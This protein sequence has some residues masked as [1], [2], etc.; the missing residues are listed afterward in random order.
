MVTILSLWLP[1]LLS[2]V[3]VFVI[4]SLIHMFFGY[5]A[6]D[7]RKVPDETSFAEA[8]RKLN[9]PPGSYSFPRAGSMAE[10]RSPAYLEK[11]KQNPGV[12]FTLWPAGEIS[13]GSLLIQWFLYSIVVGVFAAYVAGRALDANAHYLAV[14]R[15][16][17]VTAFVSYTLAGW[18][19]SI[20][21]K[22]PWST[23]MKNT[24][25]GLLYALVTAG[26]FGWLWPR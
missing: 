24:F 5:H 3:F 1:I 9:I 21:F 12:M 13:M 18:S 11:V 8:I 6:N 17:G 2:A 22:R 14:F 23:T 20:W 7:Y 10:M 26:T 25:D 4:S 15:F 19:E 16:V